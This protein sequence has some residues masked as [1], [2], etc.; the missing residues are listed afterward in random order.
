MQQQDRFDSIII[1]NVCSEV[2][3]PSYD[4]PSPA[5]SYFAAASKLTLWN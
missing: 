2:F 4:D 3:S 5:I 1:N